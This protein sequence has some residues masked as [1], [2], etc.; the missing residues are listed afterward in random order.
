[1][2]KY[3]LSWR[4][5]VARRTNLI[6]I[7]GIFVGVGALIMILSIMTGFLEESRRAIRGSLSDVII[8]PARGFGDG[9]EITDEEPD[10]ILAVLADDDRIAGASP[11]L[12]WFGLLLDPD[13][14]SRRGVIRFGST[15]VGELPF[16]EL[17]GIDAELEATA[18]AF[19]ENLLRPTRH[20]RTPVEDPSDPFAPPP[21]YVPDG[22]PLATVV[23]GEQLM[24]RNLVDRGDVIELGTLVPDPETGEMV[25]S[26]RRYVVGGYYRS[27]ENEADLARIYMD[28]RELDDL[29]GGI[30]RYSEILVRLHDFDRDKVAVVEDLKQELY[31]RG[32]LLFPPTLR[33]AEVLTWEDLR[34]S[35]LGAIQNERVLM[36]IMLSLVL[37]VAGFTIFAIL[38]MMVTEKRRDIGILTALGATP[39]GVLFLFLLIGLWDALLGALL[40]ALAGSWCAIEIDS[41][42][43][44]LSDKIGFEIFDRNVYYFDTIPSV[45]DPTWVVTI[46]VGAVLCTLVFAAIPA[47]RAS[48]QDPLDAL[49]SE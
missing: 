30:A 48:R 11:H 23:M 18:S 21:G 5:L 47:W 10:P 34:Q 19:E 26:N 22:R 27:G 15:I 9:P 24:E 33:S 39:R 46:A 14:E 44:W 25:E 42:E 1:V 49:R 12:R 31:G 28:R 32:L 37:V 41:I 16:V 6:G 13:D 3:F 2:F 20:G 36:G 45:V 38:S 40:G 29:L 35:L 43:R 17:V 4:Y 8:S 7:V